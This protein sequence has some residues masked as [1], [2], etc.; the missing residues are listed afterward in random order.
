[1]LV[2]W[3]GNNG[4]TLTASILANKLGISW[5]TKS[6]LQDPN[7]F[8]SV[9]Q[10][11]TLRIGADHLG[12]DV[13]IP[14]NSILPMVNP[15]DLVIGGWDISSLNIAESMVRAQV[16]EYDLQRQLKPHLESLK[17]L[18][19]VYYPDFI[20]S[21]Q[22]DRADNLISGSMSEQLS[23][24][25]SDIKN[26]KST[27]N[28]DQVIVLWTANTER[29][30]EIIEGVNDTS[31]NLL[32]SISNSHSEV[33]PSTLFAVASILEKCSFIN[34]SPQNTFVPGVIELAEIHNVY[35]GGDDF[36]SGQTKIKSVLVDFLVNAGIKPLSITVFYYIT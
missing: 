23:Q 35:I 11:S 31:K 24:I 20:A 29:Y 15:N 2:G 8:G 12:N 19:S 13:F 14:F 7:Y 5:N 21:N 28:L 27:N 17:P 25:Q 34:G 6:G 4:S 3:G 36:K 9:T 32:N 10:S 33:S 22:A 1:M 26:F 18:P 16:L 30:S